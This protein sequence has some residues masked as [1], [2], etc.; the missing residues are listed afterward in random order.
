MWQPPDMLV[1][2]LPVLL[3]VLL[4]GSPHPLLFVTPHPHPA[5][6]CCRS[7]TTPARACPFSRNWQRRR[8]SCASAAVT[9]P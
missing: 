7:G 9:L 2:A 6:L 1:L 3:L 5:L 4:P 8:A